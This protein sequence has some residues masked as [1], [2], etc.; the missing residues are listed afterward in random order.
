[1]LLFSGHDE[2]ETGLPTLTTGAHQGILLA[3]DGLLLTT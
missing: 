3:I 1:M 2:L